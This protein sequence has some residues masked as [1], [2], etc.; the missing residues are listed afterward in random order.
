MRID[1][2]VWFSP[3]LDQGARY[4]AERMDCE[5]AYGGVHPGEGT[6]NCLLS[7]AE[8]TYLEIVASDPAQ[9]ITNLDTELRR[10]AGSGLYHCA[11]SGL[12]LET[13]RQRAL[14]AGLQGSEIVTG[15]RSVPNG[16]RLSWKLFGLKNHDL[17]ALLPFFIDWMDSEHPAKAAPLGGEL[18]KIEVVS[19]AA[20]QLRAIYGIFDLNIATASGTVAG[21]QA[22]V[23]SRKGRQILRMFDPVPRGF[24]I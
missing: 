9:P 3:D 16:G 14:A 12:D 18:V 2:L 11:A 4:F 15:G 22:T 10:L 19:P 21:F 23:A 13:V 1:H 24:A 8:S 6:R 17:G 7:L 20:E 5:P